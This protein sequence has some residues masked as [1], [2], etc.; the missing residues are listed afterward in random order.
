MG[1]DR[2]LDARLADAR[3][4]R[5]VFLSHCLLDEN[6]RYLGGAFHGGAVPEATELVASGVGICQMPCPEQRAWGGV[7]KP[8]MLRAYGLRETRLYPLRRPLF[9]LFVWYTRLRYRWLARRVVR[10]IAQYRD[11]GVEVAALVGVGASPS[12]GVLTTLDLE[13]SFELVAG[14]PLA[15]IDRRLINE[16]AVAACRMPGEGLFMTALR[17][18][19]KR[20]GIQVRLLEY[21]LIVEM[22]GLNQRLD[23]DPVRPERK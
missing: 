22:R 4:K 2:S 23:V 7:R 11:A 21:D 6:V 15:R 9:R 14:C 10:E 18:R 1:A 17:R 20:R 19:L 8:R 12:C 16:R 3:S 13:R 5:V